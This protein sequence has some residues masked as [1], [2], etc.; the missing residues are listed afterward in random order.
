MR[1][2]RIVNLRSR[3]IADGYADARPRPALTIFVRLLP[4]LLDPVQGPIHQCKTVLWLGL[5]WLTVRASS[6]RGSATGRQKQLSC[7]TDNATRH[8]CK[9]NDARRRGE[10]ARGQRSAARWRR[11][12]TPQQPAAAHGCID[13]R[14]PAQ[15]RDRGTRATQRP[16]AMP[17]MK[18]VHS[19]RRRANAAPD[20]RPQ[21]R[22][23][24]PYAVEHTTSVPPAGRPRQDDARRRPAPGVERVPGQRGGPGARDGQQ[25]PGKGTRHHDL[26]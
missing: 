20:A 15:R 7:S 18:R 21:Q 2:F 19:P 17:G 10:G 22:N 3:Y 9:N 4:R 26:S 11:E 24:Q 6:H 12:A 23:V 13:A 5:V 8:D 25:R 16:Q 14:G 1:H